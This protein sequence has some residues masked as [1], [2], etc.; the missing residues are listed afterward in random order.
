MTS[1]RPLFTSM[2]HQMN[3]TWKTCCDAPGGP[4]KTK[5]LAHFR[6]AQTALALNDQTMCLEECRAAIEALV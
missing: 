2:S 6:A 5:A 3:D 1:D 4:G